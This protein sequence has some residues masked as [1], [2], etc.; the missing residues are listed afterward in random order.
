M[1]HKSSHIIIEMRRRIDALE[2]E[3]AELKKLLDELESED[4]E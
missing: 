4:A 1:T 2:K 3:A